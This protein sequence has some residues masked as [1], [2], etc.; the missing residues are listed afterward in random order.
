ML[1]AAA[2]AGTGL[3]HAGPPPPTYDLGNMLLTLLWG[4]PLS[5]ALTLTVT[6][7]LN[8]LTDPTPKIT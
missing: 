5:V 1:G 2:D 3:P 8:R 6:W 4:F 7:P